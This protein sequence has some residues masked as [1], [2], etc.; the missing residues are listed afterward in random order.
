MENFI[1][2]LEDILQFSPVIIAAYAGFSMIVVQTLKSMSKWITNHPLVMLLFITS[3]LSTLTIFEQ[4]KALGAV[5]ITYLVMMA[6]IGMYES[7]KNKV[8]IELS[9]L[10]DKG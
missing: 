6:A 8:S 2:Q 3:S 4:Y 9:D 5:L 1:K 7:S 10:E